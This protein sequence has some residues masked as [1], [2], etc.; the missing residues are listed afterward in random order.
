MKIFSKNVVFIVRDNQLG[1]Y[2]IDLGYF[3]EPAS[4]GM[5]FQTSD[6]FVSVKQFSNTNDM[7]EYMKQFEEEEFNFSM[8]IDS[9]ASDKVID[10]YFEDN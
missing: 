10:K 9:M 5:S 4:V 2:Y 8:A 7:L 3:V 1:S 6:N